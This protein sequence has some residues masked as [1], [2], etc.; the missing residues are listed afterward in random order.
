MVKVLRS[1]IMEAPI[2][3]VWEVI[4]DFNG[5][6]RWTVWAVCAGSISPVAKSCASSS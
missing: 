4:R 5:H 1:T 3:A 6:D 2:D